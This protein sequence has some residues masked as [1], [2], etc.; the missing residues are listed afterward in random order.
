[1]EGL[2]LTFEG[3]DGC[4]KSTQARLLER[5][6]RDYFGDA[7]VVTTK[8]P[9]GTALGAQIRSLVLGQMEVTPSRSAE[10]LLFMADRAQHVDEVIRPA[11]DAGKI[12]LCDRYVDSTLAYQGHGRGLDM[13]DI[14][15][16]NRMSSCGI[17][18][19]L[20]FVFD[21]PV[22]VAQTRVH[23]RGMSN[24]FDDLGVDFHQRVRDAFLE[25]ATNNPNRYCLISTIVE[26]EL[27][28]RMVLDTIRRRFPSWFVD[29]T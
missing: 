26:P 6:L 17:L 2:F 1:M 13:N 14:K 19:K 4:G 27:V 29:V 9:G 10:L 22:D 5:V 7:A 28:H 23:K 3:G 21:I 20:T 16:L 15:Y 25:M 12:V 11:I 24:S 8:E 18:P